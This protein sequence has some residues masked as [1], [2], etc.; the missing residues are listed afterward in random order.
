MRAEKQYEVAVKMLQHVDS[1]RAES[2]LKNTEM[3]LKCGDPFFESV[4]ELILDARYQMD[5]KKAGGVVPAVK[6][7][8]K[9]AGKYSR[10]ANVFKADVDG[11]TRYAFTD[12]FRVFRLKDDVESV[13]H[14][15]AGAFNEESLKK[16]FADPFM[17]GGALNVPSVAE[18]KQHIMNGKANGKDAAHNPICIDG[19]YLNPQ[20]L[21]DTLEILPDCDIYKPE[22]PYRALYCKGENGDGLMMPVKP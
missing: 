22:A 12:G 16:L 14:S 10:L 1:D 19:V 11:E 17:A 15:E 4:A 9:N 8:L 2:V 21:I 3:Y 5:I 18:L 13:P 6:R 20:Y 7:V